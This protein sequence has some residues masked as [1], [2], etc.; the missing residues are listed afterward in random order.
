MSKTAY[1]VVPETILIAKRVPYPEKN[2]FQHI[3]NWKM[4]AGGSQH[5]PQATC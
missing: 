2:W 5:Y 4:L 1:P 3:P